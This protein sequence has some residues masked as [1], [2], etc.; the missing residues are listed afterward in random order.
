MARFLALD[1]DHNQLHLAAAAVSGSAVRVARAAAW[2]EAQHPGA[3]DPAALGRQLRERLKSAGLGAAPVLACV[4]RDRV[5]VKEVRYPAVPAHEEPAVVRFQAVKELTDAPDEVVIDYT[6]LAEPGPSGERRALV[7]IVKRDLLAAYQAVCQAAGLKLAG[8]CPRPFAAAAC[9]KRQAGTSVLTPAPEP[10]DAAVAVLVVAGRWA[11]FTVVRGDG[12]VFARA[13]NAGPGLAGEVK[14][15]LT[16]YAGQAPRHPVTAVYL[17]GAAAEHAALRERLHDLLEVP[18]HGFDPFAGA[19]RSGI[20]ADNRGAFAGAVGLLYARGD[21]RGLPVNFAQPKQPRKQEDPVK[22]RGLIAAGL[23]AALLVGG[24]AFGYLQLSAVSR[25]VAAQYALNKDLDDKLAVLKEDGTRIKA[26]GD[27]EG[28]SVNW[29]DELY[30]LTQRFP[31]TPYMRLTQISANPAP[32]TT[33]AKN[34]HVAV[35]TVKGISTNDFGPIDKLLNAMALDGHYRVPNKETGRNA[36]HDR[37]RFSQQFSAK[38]DVSR[39]APSQFVL[40]LPDPPDRRR[41]RDRDDGAGDFDLFNDFGG[42]RP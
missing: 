31:D 12:L 9:W 40:R 17:A 14:R 4:G 7:V 42:G 13:L 25:K 37:N 28:A 6:P 22:R 20:P 18:V 21:K 41:G 36:G 3:G 29:L 1:W 23:A 2:D 10:A 32:R 5:V 33:T 39:Q 26:I 16:L 27:W 8:L 19:E 38:I 24:A 11:E 35:M 15:N 30:D 34:R